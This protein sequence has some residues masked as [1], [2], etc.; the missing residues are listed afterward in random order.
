M[1]MYEIWMFPN[2]LLPGVFLTKG[3]DQG[4]VEDFLVPDHGDIAELGRV[5]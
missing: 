5:H 2:A 1:E 4:S 3:S